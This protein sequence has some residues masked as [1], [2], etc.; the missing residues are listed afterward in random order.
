MSSLNLVPNPTIM[1]IEAGIFLANFFVVKKLL[2]EPYLESLEARSK[3]TI[4]SQSLAAQLDQDNAKALDTIS[5]RLQ[6]AAAEVR[7]YRENTLL[8][9]K[10][11][12]D[13]VLAVATRDANEIVNHVRTDLARELVEQR[14]RIPDLVRNLS[15]Q[16]VDRIVPA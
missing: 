4:G 5:R 2:L 16:L 9:A 7:L 12:R 15:Q 14:R 3:L 6:E 1:V 13:E 8:V 11:K 10:Q